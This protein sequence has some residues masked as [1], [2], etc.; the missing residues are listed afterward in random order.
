MATEM[1][2][3]LTLVATQ[4]TFSICSVISWCTY[5]SSI[6][7]VSY[8]LRPEPSAP[9]TIAALLILVYISKSSLDTLTT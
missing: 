4:V 7:S 5:S 8:T 6:A 1:K 2:R 9:P 3:Q